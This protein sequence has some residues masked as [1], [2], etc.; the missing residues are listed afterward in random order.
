[1]VLDPYVDTW[2]VTLLNPETL[3]ALP[4]VLP[5][6][7]DPLLRASAWVSVRSAVQHALLDP[8]AALDL[9]EAALPARTP[10]TAWARPS[11]GRSQDLVPIAVDPLLARARIHDVAARC[12]AGAAPGST[13]QLAAFQAAGGVA[14]GP[15]ASC[16]TGCRAGASPT[17]STSTSTCAGGCCAR[18]PGSARR[19]PRRAGARRS[20][21]EPTARVAG[22]ARAR[23]WR[24]LPDAEAKAR[25]WRR[26]TGEVDVPNYELEAA[27]MGM[28]RVGQEDLTAPYVARYFDELPATAGV[29]SGWML[30]DWPPTSTSRAG[31]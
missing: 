25:A 8:S 6:T 4:R 20:T 14:G 30:A 27:G 18:W 5:A 24:S 21:A 28:W 15:G 17:A 11:A 23:R 1:M 9:L 16:A 26:F 13:L 31:R 2:A 7:R 3:A 10:T 19:R 29:R 22:R 12:V